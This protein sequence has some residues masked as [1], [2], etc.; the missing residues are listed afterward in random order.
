MDRNIYD[1]INSVGGYDEFEKI[2]KRGRQM[3]D[4]AVWDLF[5]RLMSSG[6]LFVKANFLLK[7]RK[8]EQ[9]NHYQGNYSRYSV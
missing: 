2:V 5:A 1:V 7:F 3:H 9:R 6:I 8:K 4:A